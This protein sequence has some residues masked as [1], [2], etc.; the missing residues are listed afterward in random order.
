ML[1]NSSKSHMKCILVIYLKR[2]VM[3][4]FFLIF[5]Y[6]IYNVMLVLSRVVFPFWS[7]LGLAFVIC[8]L[9]SLFTLMPCAGTI[10][11]QLPWL[12]DLFLFPCRFSCHGYW[13]HFAFVTE[14]LT[15]YYIVT[16]LPSIILFYHH[17]YY[18]LFI[19][20]LKYRCHGYWDHLFFR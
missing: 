14:W 6:L 10:F 13:D 15:L 1:K 16:V 3:L 4:V 17:I 5:V 7:V 11:W 20:P 8:V 12:H 18:F 19:L 9:K 2:Q